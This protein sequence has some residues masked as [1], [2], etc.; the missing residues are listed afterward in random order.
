MAS[1]A[2]VLT[3]RR[4]LEILSGK[5]EHR[6]SKISDRKSYLWDIYAVNYSNRNY[7]RNHKYKVDELSKVFK[8]YN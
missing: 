5:K 4:F 1:L 6:L 8:I 7:Y 2:K 3:N